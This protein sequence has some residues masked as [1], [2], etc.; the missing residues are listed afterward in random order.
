MKPICNTYSTDM[1][2]NNMLAGG[3]NYKGMH[4]G[5]ELCY[6]NSEYHTVLYSN[7]LKFKLNE[8]MCEILAV[9]GMDQESIVRG[10]GLLPFNKAISPY[11]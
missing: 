11:H 8:M 5:I 6:L 4:P 10:I 9:M 7:R 2:S 3:F 1:Y